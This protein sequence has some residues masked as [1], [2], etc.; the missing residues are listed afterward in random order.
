M[1][2]KKYFIVV[3]CLL[4]NFVLFAQYSGYNFRKLKVQDG[5][6]DGIVRAIGQDHYGFIWIA[7]VAALN[8]F[9][10]KNFIHF[11]NIP[12]DNFSPY[13]SQPKSLFSD[14]DGNFW[15][16]YETGLVQYDFKTQKFLRIPSLKNIHV[17]F[18]TE[19]IQ[20]DLWMVTNK[21]LVKYGIRTKNTQF[22]SKQ[23]ESILNALKDNHKN[24]IVRKNHKIY[25]G[26]QKGLIIGDLDLHTFQ[27]IDIPA[28]N[29]VPIYR[30]DVDSKN[31]IWIGTHGITKLLKLHSDLKT[32]EIF[33]QYLSSDVRTQSLNIMDILVDSKNK[34]WVATLID[35]ILEYDETQNR[36][37][38]HKYNA[39]IPS[40]PSGNY[41]RC[42]FEDKDGVVWA[43]GDGNGVNYFDPSSS[44]FKVM[45]PFQDRLYER[46]RSVARGIAFDDQNNIWIGSHDGVSK[47]NVINKTYT[48]WRNDEGKK[49][50]IYNNVVRTL[51]CDDENNIW[52]GTSAGVNKYNHKTKQMEFISQ[53]DLPLRFYNSITKDKSGNIWFCTNNDAAL[54]WY[55]TK[56]KTFHNITQ[57]P[58]LCEYAHIAPTSY[59]MEDSKK[60]LWISLSKKGLILYDKVKGLSRFYSTT[61]APPYKIIGDQIID[62]KEDSKG[63]IWVSTF[64]GI[65]G[66]DIEN[67]KVM[68]FNNKNGLV[69]NKVSPIAIDKEDRLWIGATGGLM[70]L[71]QK[72]DQFTLFS[73][74][75]GL[76]SVE[77]PEH[78]SIINN[79]YEIAF[80]SNNGVILFDPE[81]WKNEY[82]KLPF[83][84]KSYTVFEK[85]Y[86]NINESFENATIE[87]KASENSFSFNLVALNYTHVSQSWFAYKLDGFD[88]EWHYTKDPK[89][90]FTN[91]PGGNYVFKYKAATDNLHWHNIPEK[92]VTVKLDTLFYKTYWFFAL[93]I[94]MASSIIY[95]FYLYR[96]N[97]QKKFFEL[98]SKAQILEKEKTAVMYENLRQQLNPHFL[99]NSLTS[100]SGLIQLDQNI[101]SKFLN[102]MSGIYRYILKN[103]NSETVSLADETEFVKI[104]VSLQQTRFTEGLVVNLNINDEYLHYRIAPV[105]IQNLIENAI[106]HN[107]ID[108]DSPLVIDI[109]IEDAYIVVRNNLQKKNLVETSNKKGLIQFVELYKYLSPLKIIIEESKTHFIIKIPLI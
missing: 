76:P 51:L 59:V 106:K 93:I 91:V 97:Q 70:M 101:A 109:Y 12:H 30:L 39:D 66:I 10:G 60:R 102:Q 84:I 44:I 63:V 77:F 89:A 58:I 11:T 34:V 54:Y 28:L 19:G 74:D 16:G 50:V 14:T 96:V 103:G 107:V 40:S 6:H 75:D 81:Q 17:Y 23:S 100:L 88:H 27:L 3:F 41:H 86:F 42:L 43:G 25:I 104:Y 80:P 26:S 13:P 7:T 99:F 47:Y 56:V 105:S 72:R 90:V 4:Y 9:D 8:R 71:N 95:V 108:E 92:K 36:F 46:N 67:N 61:E 73:E 57:H 33:D 49:P 37:I 2:S 22:V 85:E 94:L 32:V 31:N 55:D 62:I 69:G 24:D 38:K 79:N 83:F 20:K 68:S 15:I 98:Q 29:N 5:L 53:R 65:S 82:K 78:A 64:N 35:G 52:I 1:K 21:G 45:M 18:I 87:L 48:S